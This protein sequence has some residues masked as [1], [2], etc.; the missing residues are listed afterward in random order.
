MTVEAARVE[1][2]G[3]IRMFVGTLECKH[4]KN[5]R[6][7][8]DALDSTSL[9]ALVSINHPCA[10]FEREAVVLMPAGEKTGT[11]STS[12]NPKPDV[13]PLLPRD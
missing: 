7:G 2:L 10:F 13:K 3:L 6:A 5:R 8:R 9:A 11:R 1:I 4:P 12:C